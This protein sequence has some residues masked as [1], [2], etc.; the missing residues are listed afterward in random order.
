MNLYKQSVAVSSAEIT[1]RMFGAFDA[2]VKL[3]EQAFSVVIRNRN[4]DGAEHG[5]ITV[6]G[7]DASNVAN[8]VRVLENMKT[9]AAR[10]EC[11]PEQSVRYIISM[12]QAGEQHAVQDLGD[13]CICVTTRGKPIK[14]KTIGQKKY[15]QAIRKNTIVFGVGPAGKIGRAHV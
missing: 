15:V 14:A 12:V 2:N 5:A 9:V 1:A 6:E 11:V 4:G 13:D 3:I 10:E 7:G 8:A